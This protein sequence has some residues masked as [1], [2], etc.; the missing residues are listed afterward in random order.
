MRRG[1]IEYDLHPRGMHVDE[2]LSDLD[3][4][5]SRARGQGAQVFAVVTGYGSTGGTN[6][7]KESVLEACRIYKRQNHIRGFLDGEYA[8][9]MFSSEFLAFPDAA[10]LPTYYKKCPNPG[11]VIIAV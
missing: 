4:L 3:R 5:I 7:I 2:A 1:L 9:D 10:L 6:R 11:I 8:G